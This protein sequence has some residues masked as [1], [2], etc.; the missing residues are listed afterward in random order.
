MIV[1]IT[2][3]K[4]LIA[5]ISIYLLSVFVLL[6]ASLLLNNGHFVYALDDPY[7]HMTIAKN[8]VTHGLWAVN[9]MEFTSASS[10][11]LWTLIISAVYYLFGVNVITP[12][13]LNIIFGVLVIIIA[14]RILVYYEIN[15][16]VLFILLAM[17]YT[18]PMPAILFT[19]MEHTAQIALCLLFIHSGS[20]LII[21]E[22]KNS[23]TFLLLLLLIA[24]F[25]TGLRYECMFLV[26]AVCLL[27][28]LKKK[29]FYSILIFLAGLAPILF[30]GNISESHGW[31]FIPNTI[32]IKSKLPEFS[33]I[34]IPRILFRAYKNIMEPHILVLLSAGI[35]VFI[36]NCRKQKL[37][38]TQKHVMLLLF[39]LTAILH[40]TFAQNG[41]F[42]RYE[43][44][45]VA[46]GILT[47]SIN[48]FN[49]LPED[50]SLR[51][52]K[53]KFLNNRIKTFASVTI[54]APL[55]MWALTALMTPLAANNIYD[56]HYQMGLFVK[57][58]APDINI[59]ANDIGII[60]FY[61]DNYILDLWGLADINAGAEKIKKTYNTAKIQELAN[62]NKIKLAI[63]Y[64]HWFD[65]YGGLPSSWEKLGTWTITDFNIV[66]GTE[67]VTFY[68]TDKTE[69]QNLKRKL[70][71]FS[72]QLPKSV[73]HKI[74]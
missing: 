4:P 72:P 42:F 28:I 67:T 13:I 64:E 71:E 6:T 35:S 17:V 33:L 53:E 45:I 63:L 65:Q 29:V 41:W 74:F 2:K 30:Y 7:I 27:L 38:W 44:Y 57:N 52:L 40:E 31:F 25:I 23:R 66:C 32:L 49:Y 73:L 39:I 58:Y 24:P 50:F 18:A 61:S 5:A 21:S 11:P 12:F 46:M 37:I 47:I 8:F 68:S 3:T 20:K 70:E 1:N 10:S 9:G 48:V 51:I 43:A 69:T 55:I 59:A 19:G 14:Y 34:D 16:H 22:H 56:Q 26:F 60:S 54:S 62:R 36:L 15:K